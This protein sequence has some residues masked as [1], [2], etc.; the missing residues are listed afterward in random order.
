MLR[1]LGLSLL[2]I[3]AALITYMPYLQHAAKM[4]PQY[5][6]LIM[7]MKQDHA[8]MMDRQQPTRAMITHSQHTRFEEVD[9]ATYLAPFQFTAINGGNFFNGSSEQATMRG[10]IFT[11]TQQVTLDQAKDADKTRRLTTEHLVLDWENHLLNSPTPLVMV[12]QQR[13][14]YADS[15]IGNYEEGWYEFTHHVQSRWQ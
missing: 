15:L 3:F 9:E 7:E 6:T 13:E 4:T 10:H 14:I 8:S 1:I 5:T 2:A 12:D 11:L